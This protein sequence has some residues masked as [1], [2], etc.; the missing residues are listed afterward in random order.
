VQGTIDLSM[1]MIIAAS[2][3]VFGVGLM[4]LVPFFFFSFFSLSFSF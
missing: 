4:F 2:A 1:F 3:A